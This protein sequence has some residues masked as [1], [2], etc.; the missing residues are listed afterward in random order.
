MKLPT[1][2]GALA[3]VLLPVA[4]ARAQ[5]DA[6]DGASDDAA[7][8]AV[9]LDEDPPPEDMEG[10][11][12]NP[13]APK[14]IGDEDDA[15]AKLAP[16]VKR[17]GYPIEE[18]L[19]PLTLP[20]VT[21]EI[22]LDAGSTFG[23]L[24]AEVG[25]RARYG[26]TRQWQLGLRY[27]IGGIFDSVG[28][29]TDKTSFNTGKAVGIDVSYLVFDWLAARV[30][31]PFY[32]DPFATALTLG[33]PMKF[34]FGDKF[35]IVA[36]EDFLEIKLNRFVPSLTSEAANDALV[37][38]DSTGSL[39]PDANLHLGGGVIYQLS[40]QLALR[41]DLGI[42]FV[43]LSD[44]DAPTNIRGLLQY[45]PSAKLDLFGSMFID[46]LD[47]ATDTFGIRVGAAFR[48]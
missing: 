40:P 2:L 25:L 17:T 47:R 23:N 18:V 11:A 32:V 14:L 45:S 31:V 33:A 46:A 19:R 16:G 4:H 20:A 44:A 15:A 26:I 10:T 12:E 43:D 41:G 21:S 6:P 13:D 30:T 27:G 42:T 36:V 8:A 7:G 38:L 28:D 35:A 48:I 34:R 29:T 9:E 24:D 3:V 37:Q 5:G 22:A 39:T 1:L